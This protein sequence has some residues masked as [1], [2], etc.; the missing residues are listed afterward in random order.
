MLRIVHTCHDYFCANQFIAPLVNQLS[1]DGH[2]TTLIVGQGSNFNR[3]SSPLATQHALTD[4]EFSIN[5]FIFFTRVFKV[6]ILLR[7][8]NPQIIHTHMTKGALVPLVAAKLLGTKIRIYQ[9]HGLP[10]LGYKGI[11]R[12]LL[13]T[14]ERLHFK[15]ATHSYFVSQSNL[16]AARQTGLL[17]SIRCG[18]VGQGSSIGVDMS[19]FSGAH[20]NSGV[21]L[22]FR[23]SRNIPNDAVVFGYV[24][25]PVKRKGF[26]AI[27]EAWRRVSG[28]LNNSYLIIA[29]CSENEC[30][31]VTTELDS[32]VIPLG[33]V[34]DMRDFYS[35]CDSIVLPS[36]HEGFSYS[37]L[38]G[39]AAGCCLIGSDIPGNRDAIVDGITGKLF[40]IGN[41]LEL[42]EALIEYGNDLKKCKLQG[43]KARERVEKLYS[44]EVVLKSYSK[45]YGQLEREFFSK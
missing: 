24:G 9:N 44:R 36:F 31:E 11:L 14:L 43:E 1:S 10:Y 21:R 33:F 41:E 4:L 27:L 15:L 7:N 32:N 17:G 18:V 2:Q 8:I 20:L 40:D 34:K 45:L 22:A 38:E 12:F 3:D 29:G 35:Y 16:D 5:P 30:K 26:H 23:N 37:L 25:R 19:A 28:Q 13:S 39:G 6:Y 42:D